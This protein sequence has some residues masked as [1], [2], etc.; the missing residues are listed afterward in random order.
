MHCR[1]CD[2][3]EANLV[4]AAVIFLVLIHFNFDSDLNLLHFPLALRTPDS[5][6]KEQISFY[7]DTIP[8]K[9][10]KN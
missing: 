4:Q 1:G 5:W 7:Y 6:M 3:F 9:S 8:F 2:P 10:I